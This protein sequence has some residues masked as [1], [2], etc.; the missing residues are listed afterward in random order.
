MHEYAAVAIRLAF[1]SKGE[2]EILVHLLRPEIAIILG[3]PRTVDGSVF[4]FPLLIAYLHPPGEVLAIEQRDPAGFIW[5]G[6]GRSGRL[7]TIDHGGRS[8]HHRKKRIAHFHT[9]PDLPLDRAG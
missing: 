7:K 4:Y 3:D 8:Q 1:E 6:P 9:L 2:M 5:F